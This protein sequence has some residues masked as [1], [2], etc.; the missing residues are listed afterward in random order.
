[1]P[2]YTYHCPKCELFLECRHAVKDTRTR[3]ETCKEDSL[4]KVLSM[5]INLA[6]RNDD[7]TK[8]SKTG[9]VVE[10]AIEENRDILKQQQTELKKR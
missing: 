3:C 5:P 8:K 9:Q 1:M 6:N 2:A 10:A 4:Q 7:T